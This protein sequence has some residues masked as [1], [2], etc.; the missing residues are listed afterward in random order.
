MKGTGC[1]RSVGRPLMNSMDMAL[2]IFLHPHHGTANWSQCWPLIGIF[3]ESASSPNGN[4]SNHTVV[5]DKDIMRALSC[6]DTPICFVLTTLYNT[7][8][9]FPSS[10]IIQRDLK[11]HRRNLEDPGTNHKAICSGR[12]KYSKGKTCRTYSRNSATRDFPE[13]IRLKQE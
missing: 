6:L 12:F 8:I 9:S 11:D 2:L 3:L 4:M 13:S 7:I 1:S 5:S 10:G